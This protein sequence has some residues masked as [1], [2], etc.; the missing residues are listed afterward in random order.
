MLR[1]KGPNFVHGVVAQ[2]PRLLRPVLRGPF[3]VP[4]S[5]GL[6]SAHEER[7][8]SPPPPII[9]PKVR[10]STNHLIWQI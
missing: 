3:D 1:N 9:D 8:P 5:H 10:I 4:P 6:M 2:Y 7:E